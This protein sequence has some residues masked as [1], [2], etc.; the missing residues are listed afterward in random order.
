MKRLNSKKGPLVGGIV[1]VMAVGEDGMTTMSMFTLSFCCGLTALIMAISEVCSLSVCHASTAIHPISC[2]VLPL[3][4]NN[5]P[6]FTHNLFINIGIIVNMAVI[7]LFNGCGAHG[8]QISAALTVILVTNKEAQKHDVL[9]FRQ[10]FDS[11]TVGWT[12]LATPVVAINLS[13]Q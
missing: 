4:T 1:G 3:F 11:F 7:I 2:V 8:F 12:S 10:K 5:I 6:F 9:R 13:P